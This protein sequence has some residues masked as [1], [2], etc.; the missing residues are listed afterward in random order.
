MT[1][2]ARISACDFAAASARWASD[3]AGNALAIRK[4]EATSRAEFGFSALRSPSV[5][6]KSA[7]VSRVRVRGKTI[8]YENRTKSAQS[9]GLE[10]NGPRERISDLSRRVAVRRFSREA[11]GYWA[12]IRALGSQQRMLVAEGLAEGVGFEPTI[13][14]PV[15]TL[16]KRA[17]SATRPPL[18]SRAERILQYIMTRRRT[19]TAPCYGVITFLRIVIPTLAY[20]RGIILFEQRRPSGSSPGPAFW[21]HALA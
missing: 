5:L 8:V 9:G 6:A 15:Y 14:F 18:Q 11:R 7:Q 12:S 1:T 17:P 2:T 16:S 3:P 19:S 10:T 13:R 21:D 4:N 20:W